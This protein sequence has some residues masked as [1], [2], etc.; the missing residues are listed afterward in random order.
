MI[1]RLLS[2][3]VWQSYIHY[4]D[5]EE[6]GWQHTSTWSSHVGGQDVGKGFTYPDLLGP[7]SESCSSMRSPSGSPP[8]PAV[9]WSDG[10][11]LCWSRLKSQQ[12]A[13]WWRM[14]GVCQG[15]CTVYATESGWH[16]LC[17]CSY[18]GHTAVGLGVCW[19]L[20]ST[21]WGQSSLCTW[22]WLTSAPLACNRTKLK[23]TSFMWS[24]ATQSLW[25]EHVCTLALL[26]GQLVSS[27]G[28]P[29]SWR[30]SRLGL[31]PLPPIFFTLCVWLITCMCCMCVCVCV[32]VCAC[33]LV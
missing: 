8:S 28:S 33:A 6:D 10:V 13:L 16:L 29:L 15:V 14:S 19:V 26:S 20:I 5:G 11:A 24:V 12:R 4:T 22:R 17:S 30:L 23:S 27:F 18:C 9:S 3:L 25:M 2:S 31:G 7:L 32:C 1:T 21:A